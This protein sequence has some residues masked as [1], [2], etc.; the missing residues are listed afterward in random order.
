[1]KK[2]EN[3]QVNEALG[4]PERKDAVSI[5]ERPLSLMSRVAGRADIT[6]AADRAVNRERLVV[7][8]FQS[9]I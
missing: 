7:A 2:I 1:M 8:A 3:A 6:A 4:D 9:S 5:P